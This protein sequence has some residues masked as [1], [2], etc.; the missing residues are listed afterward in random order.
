M[1]AREKG[2]DAHAANEKL[3]RNVN[4]SQNLN[5]SLN[6]KLALL[7]LKKFNAKN[8]ENLEIPQKFNSYVRSFAHL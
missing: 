3:Q 5:F 6:L 7:F 1:R 2:I 4:Y 8:L